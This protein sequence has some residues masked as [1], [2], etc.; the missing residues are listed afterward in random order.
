MKTFDR[1]MIL[2]KAEYVSS[3]NNDEFTTMKDGKMVY[4]RHAPYGVNI[5]VYNTRNLAVIDFTGKVLG[6]RYKELISEETIRQCFTNIN[7]IGVCKLDTDKILVDSVVSSCDVTTD[8]ECTYTKAVCKYMR[9]HMR[10]YNLYTVRKF[11]NGNFTAAKNVT[12]P[13][14]M[15]SI[16]IYDKAREIKK[17]ENKLF[18][19]AY[20]ISADDFKNICRFEMKLGSEEQI[21]NTLE[22]PTSNLQMVL[23]SDASPI[24]DFIDDMLAP[25]TETYVSN[26]QQ[27]RIELVLKDCEYDMQKVDAKLRTIYAPKTGMT[28]ILQPYREALEE[29]N[30][31]SVIGGGCSMRDKIMQMVISK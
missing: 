28:K 10:S 9:N 31:P 23:Q 8:V 4:M 6:E 18:R 11:N 2:T 21:R 3:I 15:K 13:D 7:A 16:T 20:G 22:I 14:I 19:E 25:D 26:I 5:T 30:N 1:L 27:Y 12:D 17:Y 24:S 29:R